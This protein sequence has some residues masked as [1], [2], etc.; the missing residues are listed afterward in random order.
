MAEF[1]PPISHCNG[2][3]L[4]RPSLTSQLTSMQ[5]LQTWITPSLPHLT[6]LPRSGPLQSVGCFLLRLIQSECYG[7][8]SPLPPI[9]L[10]SS[11]PISLSPS[12]GSLVAAAEA[13]AA[14]A[15]GAAGATFAAA[16]AAAVAAAA[17]HCYGPRVIAAAGPGAVTGC[18]T[19]PAHLPRRLASIRQQPAPASV[20]C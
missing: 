4:L 14:G 11:S 3:E 19:L 8:S 15:A 18:W 20:G 2:L 12:I 17:P 6:T 7:L 5:L 13:A 10:S 16:R 9:F 1:A